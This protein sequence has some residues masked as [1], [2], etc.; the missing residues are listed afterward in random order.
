MFNKT[1]QGHICICEG[2]KTDDHAQHRS[3]LC[4]AWFVLVNMT[5]DNQPNPV[6]N[7]EGLHWLCKTCGK[8]CHF[9]GEECFDCFVKTGTEYN[10]TNPQSN[11][12]GSTGHYLCQRCAKPHHFRKGPCID[13]ILAALPWKEGD[14]VKVKATGKLGTVLYRYY[15]GYTELKIG[16]KKI[17]GGIFNN[18]GTYKNDEIELVKTTNPTPAVV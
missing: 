9:H 14:L 12:D 1:P 8:P 2:H 4:P 11:G 17:K 18:D 7:A 13:C 15:N 5:T 10:P 6:D 16:K 3:A